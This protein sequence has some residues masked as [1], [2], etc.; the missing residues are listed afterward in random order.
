M[1][2]KYLPAYPNIEKFLTEVGRR[3]FLMPLYIK[4]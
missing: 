2:K 3:K 1:E 4:K